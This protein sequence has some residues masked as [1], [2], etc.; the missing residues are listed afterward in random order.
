MYTKLKRLTAP[1]INHVG[2]KIEENRFS[3]SPVIIGGCARSGTTLVLAILAAHPSIYTI[4]N[5]I[6]AFVKWIEEISG[7]RVDVY[8]TRLDRLYR[9]FLS[10]R[11]PRTCTRW[12][13]K[14]TVNVR[15]FDKI[16]NYYR[17]KVKLIHIVRDG[18][19][20][21]T[22]I[23]PDDPEKYWVTPDHWIYEIQKGLQYL[24]YEYVYTVRYEN[25]VLNF[26]PTIRKILNFIE[27]DFHENLLEWHIHTTIKRSRGWFN[28]AE[29]IHTNSVGK[30][31]SP[32]FRKRLNTIMKHE[33]VPAMLRALNYIED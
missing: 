16:L 18:R 4:P 19:D 15:Y 11:I 32:E 7:D 10:H 8:P 24:D 1:I 31:K 27:E 33:Q 21:M 29:K 3:Q 23:H 5:E 28:T 14:D 22:S 26:E 25:L 2:R 12:C 20:V 30:W 6:R 9:H 13:E 17:N